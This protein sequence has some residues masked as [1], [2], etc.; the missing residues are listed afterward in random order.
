MSVVTAIAVYFV[1][2]WIVLFAVLPWGVK[3]P[4]NPELGHA[5]SAPE[6]PDLWRKA[7]WT[8]LIAAVVWCGYF[9]VTYFDLFSFR[10]WR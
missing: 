3:I 9:V 4:D 7:L 2:W 10:D 6:K 1:I 5:T 8:T